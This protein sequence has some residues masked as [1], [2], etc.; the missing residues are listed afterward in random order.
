M[1][2]TDSQINYFLNLANYVPPKTHQPHGET[3]GEVGF[4]SGESFLYMRHSSG[5]ME[6][7]NEEQ[8]FIVEDHGGEYQLITLEYI[9][10][11]FPAAVY[12][13]LKDKLWNEVAPSLEEI[14]RYW[15][16]EEESYSLGLEFAPDRGIYVATL[17]DLIEDS[18]YA[19]VVPPV[20]K[21][22]S[23]TYGFE[24]TFTPSA[25][26]TRVDFGN[27]A[28]RNDDGPLFSFKPH[29]NTPEEE[30][31][32]ERLRITLNRYIKNQMDAY[33]KSLHQG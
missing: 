18:S 10:N 21:I 23:L 7:R 28:I 1:T 9:L 29:V 15:D 25:P 12:A 16:C 32:Q 31:K 26:L 11:L 14:N 6:F 17:N 27:Y 5:N 20:L 13:H 22:D 2:I 8:S 4:A 30:E 33:Y 3:T 19:V 24:A